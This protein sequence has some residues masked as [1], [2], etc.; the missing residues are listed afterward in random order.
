MSKMQTN[1]PSKIVISDCFA[2]KKKGV[3]VEETGCLPGL[4]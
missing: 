2:A 1:V 4:C 3:L